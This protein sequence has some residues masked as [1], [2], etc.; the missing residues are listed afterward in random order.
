MNILFV[1]STRIGDAILSTGLLEHLRSQN[2]LI[3]VTIAC[4]PSAAPLFDGFPGLKKIIVLDKMLLSMHWLRLW[5]LTISTNWDIIID[6]RNAPITHILRRRKRFTLSRNKDDKRRVEQISDVLNLKE[7]AAPR[8][9][10]NN[11]HNELAKELLPDG[12]KILAIGPTAN[13]RAKTWPPEYFAELIERLTGS[14]GILSNGRILLLGR[15]EER[16]M[17]Q[18]LINSIPSEK[19]ID[20]IGRV[21]LLTA[22]AC[23]EKS[24][25]Y[26]GNDSGLMHL[27]ASSGIPTL[28]LFGPTK[29]ELYAPWGENTAVVRTAIPFH[30]IFPKRFEHRTSESLMGS[31][32]VDMA[33]EAAKILWIRTRSKF[34]G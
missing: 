15:D 12:E 27:A 28:G 14:T 11:Y 20:L 10:A 19:L 13:W 4:G 23:L 24:A 33:H 21:D 25:F 3:N 1:T 7:V 34:D 9:W 22:Y 6:L 26:I 2:A 5:I 31:L 29:E 18:R 30:D 8:I 16:P 17:V 32:T